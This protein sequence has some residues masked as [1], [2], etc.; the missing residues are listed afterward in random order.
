MKKTFKCN[1]ENNMC[2]WWDYFDP[3]YTDKYLYL[4]TSWKRN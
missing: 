3:G 2:V 4:E 1:K